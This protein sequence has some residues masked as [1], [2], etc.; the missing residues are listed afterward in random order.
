MVRPPGDGPPLP[1][2]WAAR[3][4]VAGA[5]LAAARLG[6][7]EL[8]ERVGTPVENLVSPDAVRRVLWTPP[9][10]TG[11]GAIAAALA[12]RGAR[13]W[14]I[15]LTTPV[16]RAALDAAIVGQVTRQ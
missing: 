3:D 14:Q 1:A 8:S 9:E 4:P 6:L 5:R 2:K 11:N 16:L 7:A 10:D 12:E 13:P 15:E